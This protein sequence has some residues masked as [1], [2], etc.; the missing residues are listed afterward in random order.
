VAGSVGGRPQR[1]S[2][3]EAFLAGQAADPSSA[4]AAAGVIYD[5]VEI[6]PDPFESDAYKRQL[7]RAVGRRAI[8]SALQR[9]TGEE[10]G[11]HAA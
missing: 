9:A 5:E 11:R 10:G 8:A 1:L 7:A 4:V 6:A 2:R 3:T